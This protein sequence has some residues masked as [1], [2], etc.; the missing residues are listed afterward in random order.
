MI[1]RLLNDLSRFDELLRRTIWLGL[2][3]VEV[4]LVWHSLRNV[5]EFC[6]LRLA[7]GWNMLESKSLVRV[8][9]LL[10]S[11]RLPVLLLLTDV[12]VCIFQKRVD[13]V[14]SV[15]YRILGR[16]N[17]PKVLCF[18]LWLTAIIIL[19]VNDRKRL[20]RRTLCYL[21]HSEP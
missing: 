11:L 14:G 8:I 12:R 4:R 3:V 20:L 18:I 16:L 10:S 21:L 1:G 17:Q 19:I 2:R 5:E 9:L 6:S 7:I 15:P 13:F